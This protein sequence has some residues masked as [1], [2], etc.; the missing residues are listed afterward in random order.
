MN[1]TVTGT[2]ESTEDTRASRSALETDI[3]VA[4]ERSRSVFIIQSLNQGNRAV[5]LGYTLIFVRKSKLG[6]GT[7]SD[8]ETSCIRYMNDVECNH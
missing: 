3:E 8:E 5:R 7:T 1:T 4:L 2:L 6:Q